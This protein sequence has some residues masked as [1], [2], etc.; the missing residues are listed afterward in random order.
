M[1]L[2]S[3]VCA[4][5]AAAVSC[6]APAFDA[7]TRS[8]DCPS[9]VCSQGICQASAVPDAGS[10][11][12]GA[13]NHTLKIVVSGSGSVKSSPGGIDCAPTCTGIFPMNTDVV[14]TAAP[15]TSFHFDGWTGACSG[16]STCALKLTGD[17]QAFA[18]F[19]ADAPP[20]PG[21]F[22]VTVS[23]AGTGTGKVTSTPAGL[24]C[25]SACSGAFTDGQTLTLAQ[26]AGADS[27]FAGWGGA[28]SGAG[29]C[30][31]KVSAAT[32]VTATFDLNPPPVDECLGLKPDP[33][34]T[35]LVFKATAPAA[36]PAF[37]GCEP[38]AVDGSGNLA[39][40]FST[41][42]APPTWSY[43]FLDKGGAVL[44]APAFMGLKTVIGQLAG[45]E[46]VVVQGSPTL[47][48]L[49]ANGKVLKTV[50]LTGASRA[51]NDPTGGV[52]VYDDGLKDIRAYDSSATLRWHVLL[53]ESGFATLGV[54][55][56]GHVLVLFDGTSR[57]G[58]GTLAGVW[59][60]HDGAAKSA[61][62]R[63]VDGL[64]AT[65]GLDFGTR[66][67]DGLFLSQGGKWIR[68]FASRATS[69]QPPPDWLAKRAPGKLR[70]ARNAKAYAFLPLDG[71]AVPVCSQQLEIVAPTGKSCGTLSF[72]LSAAACTTG[73]LEVG[74]DGTVLQLLPL[75]PCGPACSCS[76]R[77]YPGL[78]H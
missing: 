61:V 39:L 73:A 75:A 41:A 2:A 63:A 31:F 13:T 8:A 65:T 49:G 48:Q 19:K 12:T 44:G 26:A 6:S 72:D 43:S 71:A 5:A 69:S 4:A 58:A 67:G 32:A 47:Y 28:C 76:W 56:A 64:A 16:T 54:D 25:P 38:G 46:G 17:A 42:T 7:C 15:A 62:F 23:P 36:P 35:P 33:A 10:G 78:V 60:D 18:T 74:Y 37:N 59:I 70:M 21:S 30:S 66:V 45:F 14:L 68:A 50:A 51:F 27:H 11:D 9:G 34:G 29:A 1:K 52:V 3:M 77:W 55:R 22:T 40:S 20:P 53:G 24:D 57:Y